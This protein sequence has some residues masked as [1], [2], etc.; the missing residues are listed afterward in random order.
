MSSFLQMCTWSSGRCSSSSKQ[1]S[2]CLK[3]HPQPV[4]PLVQSQTSP[5]LSTP[6]A[7]ESFPA[8]ATSGSRQ[9][10]AAVAAAEAAA[11]I[12]TSLE[13]DFIFSCNRAQIL[14]H[15]PVN[16]TWFVPTCLAQSQTLPESSPFFRIYNSF[17]QTR[18][19][20]LPHLSYSVCPVYKS[21]LTQPA[22]CAACS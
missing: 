4:Q 12:I 9:V 11:P 19:I 18:N 1:V 20:M 22:K 10:Q 3:W 2:V 13:K 7:I 8:L 6:S 15:Y 17:S 21:R 14:H 16:I 5:S